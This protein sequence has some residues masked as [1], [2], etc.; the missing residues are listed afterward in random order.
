[1]FRQERSEATIGFSLPF[2]L[3]KEVGVEGAKPLEDGKDKQCKLI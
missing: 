3:Q 1:M 2:V